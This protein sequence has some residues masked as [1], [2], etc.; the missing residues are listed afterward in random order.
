MSS[1]D[2]TLLPFQTPCSILIVGPTQS[3]KTMLTFRIIKQ[4]GGMFSTPPVKIVYCYSV[5][6]ELFASMEKEI[7]NITFHEGL[8]SSEQVDAWSEKREHM[9]LIL[10]DLLATAVNDVEV[11]NL[12]TVKSHHQNISLL[13]LTQNLYHS[14]GKFMRTISLN[15]SYIICLKNH[16]DQHQLTVLAKQILPGQVKYFMSAYELATKKKYGYLAID[17]SAHTDKLYLLRTN[18]FIGENL[19]GFSSEIILKKL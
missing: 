16:R 2:R 14:P 13:M 6:Q 15:A 3:V 12:F 19:C 17:L 9:L 7:D 5:Y 18:I 10:D 1:G 4:A 11:L 8:P